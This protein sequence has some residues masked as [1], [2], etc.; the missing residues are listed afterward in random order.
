MQE[1][2]SGYASVLSFFLKE[3][4]IQSANLQEALKIL[5]PG[6]Y[7]SE[8]VNPILSYVQAIL[9][10]AKLARIPLFEELA[11]VLIDTLLNAKTDH[12]LLTPQIIEIWQQSA[13]LFK[14]AA[15]VKDENIK[16][17]FKF[18]SHEIQRNL[19]EL[20]KLLKEFS[21][22]KT[23][24]AG[25]S[26][27]QE[28]SL[29]SSMMNLF[30]I[31]LENQGK[32]LNEG[33]ISL[34][35]SN[36]DIVQLPALMRAAHSIKGAAKVVALDVII[37]LAHCLEDCFVAA[38][39]Q[40]IKLDDLQIDVLF[41][42]VDILLKLSNV[43]QYGITFWLTKEKKY[44]DEICKAL[45]IIISGN[46]LEQL[47]SFSFAESGSEIPA[48]SKLPL[49][50]PKV[51]QKD[52]QPPIESRP[53]KHHD[54][55][56]VLRV[57]A[58]NLN[59]LMGLA[60]ESMVEARWL[61]PFS[62][63]LFNLK[64]AQNTVMTYVDLVRDSLKEA[65]LSDRVKQYLTVLQHKTNECRQSLTD[66]LSELEMF[67]SR[68]SS[69]TDRLYAEVIDSRMRPFFDIAEGYSRMVRDLARQLN[70][71]VKLEIEGRDTPVDRDIL[72]KLEAPL[73]H[74]LRN[75]VD[76]GI[77]T[78]EERILV[79]KPPEGLIRLVAHHRAGM[80]AISVSDDGRGLDVETLRK[81]IIENNMVR[82]EIA[83]KLTET[84]LLDFLFLPGFSTAKEVTEISG[85]GIGLNIV[86]NMVQE[87]SGAVRITVE[88]GKGMTVNLQLPLTLSVI[89]A[90]IVEIN[91]EAYAFP[92]ARLVQSLVVPQ[93]KIEN[94]ENRQYF[95]F[96][97]QNIGLVSAAQVLGFEDVKIGSK[98]F[99]VII[100]ND[101]SNYYGIVVDR[102]IGERELV[103]HELD[104]RLGKTPNIIA[105]SFLEDGDPVLIID[106][107]DIVRSI[108]IMLSGGRLHRLAYLEDTLPVKRKKRILVID[109]SI[110]VREVECRLLR[111]NGYEV[112]TAVNG[113]DGWNAI[114]IGS[115]DLVVT[116]IDMPRMNGI[117]LVRAIKS[118]PR[119]KNL[120]VMIVSYKERESDRLLGLDAG[121][122][123][124]LTKSSFHDEALLSAV[125]DLIGK[126]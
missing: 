119:L 116:D 84:E 110:T 105:G 70:K 98:F 65:N 82:P 74:L 60:G 14:K 118:D 32:I 69:L 5:Q 81:K 28:A 121:A 12:V 23:S 44:I 29:D 104:P 96:E 67:I 99:S 75:A 53:L 17:F 2:Q 20:K 106:A 107:E 9:G 123:Y 41:R 13:D 19:L 51:T 63:S 113:I 37:R 117:E 103:V 42:A 93:E 21:E 115:Y 101:R 59:R 7:L 4:K 48:E 87:V 34:E 8:S 66:R 55:D 108:D 24:K 35:Q 27:S 33:L 40:T 68:H 36:F 16:D 89:R 92:L 77:G 62:G 38:Q 64:K 126:P 22:K 58:Q 54:Q 1:D 39:N 94:I 57:T 100:L 114:R 52:I 102:F 109:D 83:T 11:K 3:L 18:Q 124:Y 78:P 43:S 86:Q 95:Y 79:G 61:T 15:N 120:P 71:K 50:K 25:L 91:G 30:Q 90:L 31:E 26:Q 56:R 97:R 6:T 76:H 112:E 80:L 122:N 125:E 10:G 111:N 49:E 46:S 47:S 72:E 45:A 85:R 88:K 73:S